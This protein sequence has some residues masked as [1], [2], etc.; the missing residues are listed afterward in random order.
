M[1]YD[2]LDAL[3]VLLGQI[4]L[5]DETQAQG[6][7]TLFGVYLDALHNPPIGIIGVGATTYA[8]DALIAFQLRKKEV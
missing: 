1:I 6:I 4:D 3:I 8:E 7:K 2:N 5:S